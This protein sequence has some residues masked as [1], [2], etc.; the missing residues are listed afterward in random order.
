MLPQIAAAIEHRTTRIDCCGDLD[1]LDAASRVFRFRPD[2]YAYMPAYVS[3]QWDGYIRLL[4]GGRVPTGLFL[5]QLAELQRVLQVCVTDNRTLPEFG[6]P[7]VAAWQ[8]ARPYQREC[9]QAMLAASGTGGI[10]L[11]ST[12][13][14][15]T[16]VA[17][18]Y[19]SALRGRAMFLVDELT[20][21][22]QAQKAIA[23][24]LQE[25]V[26][27]FGGG[28]FSPERITV[29]TVQTLDR[30]RKTDDVRKFRPEVVILD[31]LHEALNDRTDRVLAA[32][33]P[34]AVFGLTATLQMEKKPIRFRAA[35]TCGP[36][37]YT[38]PLQQ[39]I[40]EGH[41]A[42][43]V[44]VRVDREF[45]ACFRLF[46]KSG[47]E[48]RYER[49]VVDNHARNLYIA[50]LAATCARKHPT[51]LLVDRIRHLENLDGM[52]NGCA[53]RVLCGED[54]K[55]ERAQAISD[56]IAG[57]LNLIVTNRIFGKGVDIPNL[58]VVIDATG[59]QSRNAAQQR[60]GRG[61]RKSPGKI[62]LIH[63]D[64]ADPLLSATKQR[65]IAYR[66]LKVPIVDVKI[67]LSPQQLLDYAYNHLN[68]KNV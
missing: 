38:Y 46:R 3:G 59:R 16:F 43:G 49:A 40:E 61:S 4:R 66:K 13:S 48:E 31:E 55:E 6:D 45:G 64:I 26:G 1:A 10:V 54:A 5:Q 23:S 51:I 12:G 11:Q 19:F 37:I 29:S 8:Q 18:L 24:V 9:Y 68:P 41:L 47:A 34:K 33:K 21:L 56:M 42:Q 57:K 2:G 27:I 35:A 36:V 65:L 50:D 39:G 63:I 62:G 60:L 44:V 7:A 52:L 14:G 67:H 58:E 30:R 28:K 22:G 32:L 53:R 17:G 20:L 15:K 25:P